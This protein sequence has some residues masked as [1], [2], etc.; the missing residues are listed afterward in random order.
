MIKITF[1]GDSIY[2]GQGVD[3]SKGWVVKVSEIL[4]KVRND[5]EV[6][7]RASN[8]RTSRQALEVM[9]YEIQSNPPEILVIQLGMN[10]GNYWETDK[11]LPRVSI[12]AFEAN[13]EEIIDRAQIFNVKKI[14][15]NT[16]H[17]S[18]K[19][20]IYNVNNE[21]YNMIIRKVAKKKKVILN[22]IEKVFLKIKNKKELLLPDGIHLNREGHII[23]FTTI[24][25]VI[26]K[27]I[28]EI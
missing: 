13:L 11:G 1:F 22:D 15:M 19:D 28:K 20:P 2:T 3:L 5:I 26:L 27:A 12:K 9:P 21:N 8:G 10:D 6:A 4:S 14:I 16:N 24:Y 7:I 25:P 18:D 23:Y 17:P